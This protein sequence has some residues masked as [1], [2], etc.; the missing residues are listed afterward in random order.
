MLETHHLYFSYKESQEILSD[1]SLR[2][3]SEKLTAI[4]GPNGTGKTTLLK[5]MNGILLPTKGE[6]RFKGTNLSELTLLEIAKKITYVP[7]QTSNFFPIKVL[8]CVLMGRY[9]Y[10]SGKYC[11][12]D[13]EIAFE[14]I[15]K[16]GLKDLA[17]R[18][19]QEISGGE[20]QRALIARALAQQPEMILLDEPT[21]N[22]DIKNQLLVLELLSHLTSKDG[23]SIV[24]TVHDLNLASMYADRIVMLNRAKV[25]IDGEPTEVLTEKTVREIYQVNT[26]ITEEE[27]YQ[28]IRL[29][30]GV[31]NEKS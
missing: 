21:N 19:L 14:I 5:C 15:E 4:L 18:T 28:H 23:V 2:F 10:A 3:E 12:E 25:F 20:R 8:D 29:L 27:G 1:I 26:C 30:K 9:P 31:G 7:Q 22:L 16:M 17:F 11:L 6:V 13:R 24:M